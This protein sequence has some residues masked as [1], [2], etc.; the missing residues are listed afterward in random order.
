MTRI[1]RD[2]PLGRVLK[3]LQSLGFHVVRSGTHIV[4]VRDEPDG[5]VTG[6]AIPSHRRVKGVTLL[7]AVTRA[8]VTREELAKAL[9][10]RNDDG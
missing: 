1:P 5:T 7:S 9:T 2:I 3:A 10:G 6:L 8:G 4:L